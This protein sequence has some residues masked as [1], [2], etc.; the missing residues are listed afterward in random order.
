MNW[1]LLVT[2]LVLALGALLAIVLFV[3]APPSPRV[4]IERRLAPGQEYVSGL[5]R[6]A[7]RTVGALDAVFR[8]NRALF[9]VDELEL[10]GVRMTPPTFLLVTFSAALVAAL[11]G[12]V[13]GF[14]SIRAPIFAV[15]F[16]ILTPVGAKVLLLVRAGARR[17]KFASQLDDTL[18][19]ISGNLRAGYG[20]VQALDAVGRDGDEPTSSEFTRVVNETRIGR[21]LSEALET[22]AARMRSDDFT[23]AA[24][25]ITVNRETGGNLAEVLEQ[26]GATIRERNQIRRQVSALSAEGRLSAIVLVV[27]PVAVFVIVALSQ[28]AYLATFFGSI[29]GI[30]ALIGSAVLLVIGS[31]WMFAVARVKF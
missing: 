18:Q 31:V 11:I 9:R 8:G 13:I 10:A 21:D 16:A 6:A 1:T 23:W 3:I 7:D 26:V 5:S 22:T 2:G 12:V 15:L 4:P 28:P 25:A 29:P 27:L 17:A 14:D 19:L 24:Q 30:L 20:L